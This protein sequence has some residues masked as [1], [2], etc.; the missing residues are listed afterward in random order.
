M[1]VE[2]TGP[3]PRLRTSAEIP[4]SNLYWSEP[5]PGD[6]EIIGYRIYPAVDCATVAGQEI[7]VGPNELILPNHLCLALNDAGEGFLG[8]YL[9]FIGGGD[10]NGLIAEPSYMVATAI[11]SALYPLPRKQVFALHRA[12]TLGDTAPI[13]STLEQLAEFGFTNGLS[14][15][16]VNPGWRPWQDHLQ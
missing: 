8:A 3:V 12:W 9:G 4:Y 6:H 11:P 5:E 16:P 14:A 10:K 1:F 2:P 7:E 13:Q 15:L